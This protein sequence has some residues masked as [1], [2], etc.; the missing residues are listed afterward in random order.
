MHKLPVQTQTDQTHTPKVNKMVDICPYHYYI[1]IYY[2]Y[3]L[4][5]IL[6]ILFDIVSTCFYSICFCYSIYIYIL[7]C[8]LM[9]ESAKCWSYLGICIPIWS[10]TNS[11]CR[12]GNFCLPIANAVHANVGRCIKA[13]VSRLNDG[14][15]CSNGYTASG[16]KQ[17]KLTSTSLLLGVATQP[18]CT[19]RNIQHVSPI[20]NI[21]NSNV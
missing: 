13:A 6:Y 14:R 10:L 19:V 18:A 5:Y 4:N 7:F 20:L 9:S 2:I 12:I 17:L 16:A 3:I 1:Y 8:I 11:A 15:D 21:L